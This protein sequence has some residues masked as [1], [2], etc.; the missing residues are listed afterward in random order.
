[1]WPAYID[2]A[3]K[4][5]ASHVL[6]H[7]FESHF[8]M[9]GGNILTLQ[10]VLGHSTVTVTMRYAHLAP[11]YLQAAVSLSPLVGINRF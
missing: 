6:R 9:N 8:M 5:Q 11:E 2:Y 10:N 4:G 1:M 7:T 3:A